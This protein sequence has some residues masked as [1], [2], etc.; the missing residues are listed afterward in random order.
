MIIA[1]ELVAGTGFLAFDRLA[2]AE[3]AEKVKTISAL[4]KQQVAGASGW[5]FRARRAPRVIEMHAVRLDLEV[6]AAARGSKAFSTVAGPIVIIRELL[7]AA[8]L[9]R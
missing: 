1:D 3:R 6:L 2:D 5:A 8:A 7:L 4:C 9:H